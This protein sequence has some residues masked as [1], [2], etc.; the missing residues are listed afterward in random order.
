MKKIKKTYYV[1]E[2]ESA[3]DKFITIY[4]VI[5]E[6]KEMYRAH[7]YFV[8]YNIAVK[9][10]QLEQDSFPSDFVWIETKLLN[11]EK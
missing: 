5:H 2:I 3:S 6:N 8:D 9:E 7:R 4:D 11:A 10:R 1:H